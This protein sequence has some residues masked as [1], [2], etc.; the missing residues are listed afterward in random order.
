[1]KTIKFT[2]LIVLLLLANACKD[3]EELQTDP[4]RATETHPSLLLT[5]IE[6]S[7]FNTIDLSAGLATRMLVF[8]DGATDDQYYGWLR[9]GFGRYNTMRQV[10]KMDE[11]AQRLGSGLDN[12]RAL[13]LF[14]NSYQIFELT[15]VFGDV[16]YRESVKA[17]TNAIYTP[18]YD[19]QKDIMIQVLDDLKTAN[20]NLDASR[21][22]LAG[23]VIYK[24]DILKW[25][26]LI[27][28]FA[29]RVLITLSL[30]END[31]DLDIKT[32]F[33]EI[34]SDPDQYPIFTSNDDNAAL[35]F[36]NIAGNRYPYFNNNSLKT[37][38]YMEESFVD[39]LKS[40]EDPRLFIFA[41]RSPDGRALPA[42]D[43]D[44]YGGLGGSDPLADN[45]NR[46]LA[47]EASL[48]DTLYYSDPVNEPSIALGYAE[49]EFTLAE[50]AARGWITDDA[51]DH[52]VKG[53]QA[54]MGFHKIAETEQEAY[55]L[56]PEV[57]FDPAKDIE[58]IITQKYISYFMNG[59]WEPFY[60]HLRTGFPE[61]SV[62]GGGVLNDGK[63]PMRWMYPQEEL[64]LNLRMLALRSSGNIP[65]ATTS[66]VSCGYGKINRPFKTS[67]HESNKTHIDPHTG[68]N[69]FLF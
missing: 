67:A 9:A 51:E 28:S 60:N 44:A 2:G 64:L 21:T 61:F 32:R 1:M 4:N 69:T 13:A 15:K 49:V 54:S 19:P 25:K 36:V 30:K 63:V 24:G 27:N 38:Y 52:Y 45:T 59:G 47:G 18:V 66:M 8:T 29:L 48:V 42:T 12:Y 68:R 17:T 16:P 26:K 11:E 37:A 33:N 43:F 31:V 35:E 57:V 53:I 7:S 6:V 40:Y 22:A 55:L 20:A 56:Q 5:N 46:L 41:D 62:D 14:F 65:V 10:A 34:V 58:M 23:D 50:A 3:F 39:R